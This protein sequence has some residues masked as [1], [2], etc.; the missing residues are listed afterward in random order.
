ME[1]I[2]AFPGWERLSEISESE[3]RSLKLG[4][5]A[6]Y[7]A[8]SAQII[9]S[10][11]GW[12]ESIPELSYEKAKKELL[13]LPGVGEKVADCVLLFGGNFWRRFQ[14]ILGSKKVWKKKILSS[15]ME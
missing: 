15:R 14:L 8:K 3:L 9:V 5:R 13:C 2:Y 1:D 6:K 4:Y 12:L 11:K 10:R 7:V